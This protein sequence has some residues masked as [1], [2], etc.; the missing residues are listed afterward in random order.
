MA[1][2][3]KFFALSIGS[4]IIVAFVLA[5]LAKPLTSMVRHLIYSSPERGSANQHE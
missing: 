1:E 2:F 5:G 4:A 3:L